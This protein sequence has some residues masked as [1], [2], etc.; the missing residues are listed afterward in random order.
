MALCETIQKSLL[1]L[2][3]KFCEHFTQVSPTNREKANI[4]SFKVISERGDIDREV[5][6]EEEREGE[7]DT[8]FVIRLGR[9]GELCEGWEVLVSE[10]F[11]K[12]IDAQIFLLDSQNMAV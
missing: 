10:F 11:L 12:F 5:L 9:Q 2:L 4:S 6:L 7:R 3:T 8:P 1:G